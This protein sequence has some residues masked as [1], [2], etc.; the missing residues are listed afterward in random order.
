MVLSVERGGSESNRIR[1]TT[2]FSPSWSSV[3]KHKPKKVVF[4]LA[5]YCNKGKKDEKK[6]NPVE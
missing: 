4:K 1:E 2:P 5:S 3:L 6:I